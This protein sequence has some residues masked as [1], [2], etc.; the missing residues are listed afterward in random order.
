MSMEDKDFDSYE[1]REQD[2]WLPI[3][4]VDRVMR[5]SLPKNAK[6]SKEAKECMQE[7]VSE[8]ISFITSQAAEKCLIEKRKT[9]NGEDILYS[10]YSLGFE[11]YAEVLRIYLAKYR[12]YELDEVE[13]RRKKYLARKEKLQLQSANKKKVKISSVDSPSVKVE[14]KSSEAIL[15][16]TTSS[17]ASQ[18]NDQ[19]MNS[20]MFW[21][22]QRSES[23]SSES[24]TGQDGIFGNLLQDAKSDSFETVWKNP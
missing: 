2:R 10:L 23:L 20:D 5:H 7:C 19:F 1:I 16:G 8:F 12:I 24:S 9:L 17:A 14:P 4:N 21:D 15:A 13:R 22:L 11:N 6:I 3:A 18:G